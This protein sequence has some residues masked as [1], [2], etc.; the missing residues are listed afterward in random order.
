M[1]Y[2]TGGIDGVFC[3]AQIQPSIL[4][5]S[6]RASLFSA[7]YVYDLLIAC[8]KLRLLARN[9][10]FGSQTGPINASTGRLQVLIFLDMARFFHPILPHA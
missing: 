2:N 7:S 1:V 3:H 6:P 9:I 10:F 4:S 8:G 5:L